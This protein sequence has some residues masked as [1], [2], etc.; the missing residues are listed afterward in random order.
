[1]KIRS[2]LNS[3]KALFLFAGVI[4]IGQS[5][6]SGDSEQSAQYAASSYS[7]ARSPCE[8]YQQNSFALLNSNIPKMVQ[9]VER[10]DA[11]QDPSAWEV[12]SSLGFIIQIVNNEEKIQAECP[13]S[14]AL[15]EEQRDEVLTVHG[16]G[17]LLKYFIQ[18][19]N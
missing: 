6:T 7:S 4:T 9:L 19:Q 1:M 16:L 18:S 5:C 17:T 15:Y 12:A 3:V 10:M 11:G 13:E 8:S 14:F 2:A